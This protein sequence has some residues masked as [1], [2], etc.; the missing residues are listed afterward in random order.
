ML[1]N[2]FNQLPDYCAWYE[3]LH[4]NLLTH[5]KYVKPKE[6]HIGIDDYWRNYAALPDLAQHHQSAF[7]QNTL[8]MEKYV[9]WT[10]LE[11]YINYLIANS[12]G[13]I[14]VLQFNRMDLRL[15]W[16]KNTFPNATII[17]IKRQP[18][19]LWL[20]CRKHLPTMAC[21]VNESHPDAYDLMQWS[22]D[23]SLTFPMLQAKKNRHSYYRHYFIWKLAQLIA[24][25]SADVFLR[26]E[27]DF[28]HSSQG[29]EKLAQLFNWSAENKKLAQTFI[30]Q[31]EPNQ[32][33]DEKTEVQQAIE[34]QVDAQFAALGLT[35]YLPSSPLMSTKLENKK[36]WLKYPQNPE[37]TVAEL[38]E[39]IKFQK[40]E[41]TALVN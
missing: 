24:D 11:D 13:K 39:A 8:F 12:Q 29:L 36:A 19:P 25:G 23:L 16:L 37:I 35:S 20:S 31:P 30:L 34:Q 41:M 38:L 14:P 32:L 9:K 17:H 15:G 7:G 28:H 3:P 1:W 26:L 40:D 18:Y 33:L 21:K 10:E 6:D 4:P 27:E 2:L 5:I 22:A